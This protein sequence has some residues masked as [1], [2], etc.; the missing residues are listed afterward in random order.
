M[1]ASAEVSF[2]EKES[3]TNLKKVRKGCDEL[4]TVD[5]QNFFLADKSADNTAEGVQKFCIYAHLYHVLYETHF[6]V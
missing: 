4:E 1:F 2:S 5:A 3:C 6:K